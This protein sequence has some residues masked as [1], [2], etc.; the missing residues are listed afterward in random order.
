MHTNILRSL[1]AAA[2]LATLIAAAPIQAPAAKTGPM[3]CTIDDTHSLA[4][5]RVHHMGAGQFWGRFNDVSGNFAFEAG[6]AEGMKFDITIKTESVDTGIDALN[7]HLR[8][9]DFFGAKDFPAMTFKSTAAKKTGETTYDVSGDLTIH[10]VTKPVVAKLEFTGMADMGKGMNAGFE[11][12]FAVKRSDFGMNYG[13]KQGALGD[14]VKVV[15][16]LEGGVAK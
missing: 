3:V 10:G 5:F 16:A 11:A 15:V 6:K 7:K 4:L 14:D 9:P 1:V 2:S 13:I 8:S 12:T